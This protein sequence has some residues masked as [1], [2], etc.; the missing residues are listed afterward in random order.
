V[1]K[2]LKNLLFKIPQFKRFQ[3]LKEIKSLFANEINLI[4]NTLDKVKYSSKNQSIL[5][6]SLNKAATQY[7]KDILC[8]IADEI[9]LL[10]IHLHEYAFYSKFKYFT[11]Q[12]QEELE[13]N[14]Y[15]FKSKG[16]LYSVFGGFFNGIEDIDK[17]KIIITIRDPRDII[18]SSY[19]SITVN[20]MEPPKTSDKYERFINL[21]KTYKK[22]NIDDFALQKV[23]SVKNNFKNYIDSGIVRK[24]N[25]LLL[26]YENMVTDF[27]NWLNE[28]FDFL[29]VNKSY[30]IYSQLIESQKKIV[31]KTENINK[32]IRKGRAGDYKE[33]LSKKTIE[34]INKDLK[35]VLEYFNYTIN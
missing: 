18:V 5:H 2:S 14:Q 3:E 16:I 19:F 21:R 28:L 20:H 30:A 24:D 34:V 10:P 13:N 23:K 25:V 22:L 35:E 4:N 7:T 9:E 27:P 12:S 33:K 26:K 31:P 8:K 1:K 11:S 29:E 17:Y 32:H 6:F 15:L